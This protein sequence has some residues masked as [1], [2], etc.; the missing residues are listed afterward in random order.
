MGE[1]LDPL[2]G[3]RGVAAY[4]VLLGHSIH[5]AF[6]YN[7][8][9]PLHE[10]AERLAYFG[11]SLFFVLS[12]FVMHYNYAK[13]IQSEG[14]ARG[15]YKFLIA[16]LARLYPLYVVAILLPIQHIPFITFADPIVAASYALMLQSW[17][18]FPDV[19][20]P[21]AWS[22]STEAFFYLVFLLSAPLL[23]RIRS[24]HIVLVGLCIT[25]PVVIFVVLGFGQNEI[26]TWLSNHP[27]IA[28][29]Q[30]GRAISANWVWV[31]YYSPYLR[32]LEFAAGV[33]ASMVFEMP[34]KRRPAFY[35]FCI[36]VSISWCG[37]VLL[38][39][40]PAT[41]LPNFIFAPAL[42]ALVIALC[43]SETVVS[44]VLSRP[45][46]VGAGDISYSVYILQ[47]WMM[48]AL[49][50]TFRSTMP[51]AE[52]YANSSVLA[53][54]I[55]ALTT[56]TSYGS[57]VLFEAPARRL[58]RR[59]LEPGPRALAADLRSVFF[60]PSSAFTSPYLRSRATPT[61]K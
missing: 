22:V 25:A 12:G 51:S 46:A 26:L 36:A 19:L 43:R 55:I 31:S 13:V 17:F 2:T 34:R 28:H 37:I 20:F 1:R 50:G 56:A 23:P 14:L 5:F 58:I 33:L 6:Q 47:M 9:G 3:L 54:M 15:G 39:G 11:M 18:G 49:A 53:V 32:V 59:W 29:S 4:S 40:A 30:D 57:Y 24:P 7:T 45:L 38:F 41:L 61:R 27:W 35:Q 44:R 48:A 16:R 60:A 21:P 10:F 52:A 8:I 42:A